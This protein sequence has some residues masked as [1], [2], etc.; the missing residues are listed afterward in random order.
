MVY[1]YVKEIVKDEEIIDDVYR[2]T[3][4][5]LEDKYG[6]LFDIDKKVDI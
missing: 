5:L 6:I 1:Q 3:I 4:S 2:A